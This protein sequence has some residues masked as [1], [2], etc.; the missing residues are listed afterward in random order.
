MSHV[1]QTADKKDQIG[2]R[3]PGAQNLNLTEKVE[4]WIRSSTDDEAELHVYTAS[5]HPATEDRYPQM[6]ESSTEKD[7]YLGRYLRG[8]VVRRSLGSS[9]R[10]SRERATRTAW[11]YT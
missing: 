5:Q 2:N 6:R 4:L 1:I 7:S 11:Y 3:L 8:K 9:T 10:I